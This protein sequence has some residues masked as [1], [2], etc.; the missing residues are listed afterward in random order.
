MQDFQECL[1][2]RANQGKKK[3]K[4]LGEQKKKKGWDL[5]K[6]K[7]QTQNNKLHPSAGKRREENR[8]LRA[9]GISN[10]LWGWVR[11]VP[12]ARVKEELKD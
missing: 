12:A 8:I 2:L 6:R 4:F 10:A 5:R 9:A 3:K 1:F 11:G 7:T